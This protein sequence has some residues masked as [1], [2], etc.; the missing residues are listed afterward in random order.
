MHTN[1]FPIIQGLLENDIEVKFYTFFEGVTEDHSLL[2]PTPLK[3][4]LISKFLCFLCDRFNDPNDAETKKLKLYMPSFF[5]ILRLIKREQPDLI[6]LRDRSKASAIVALACKAL[7]FKNIVIYNQ[8]S[9]DFTYHGWKN[10][11]F[12]K[13]RYTPV[14]SVD[15][16]GNVNNEKAEHTYFIPFVYDVPDYEKNYSKETERIKILD[17]GKYRDYKNH[18]ILVEAAKILKDRQIT[19]FNITIVGQVNNSAEKEYFD[20][21]SANINSLNLKENISLC[22]SV[23]YNQIGNLYQSHD[24]LVLPS[25]KELAGMV[26]LESMAYGLC[27]ISSDNNG[28][29]FYIVESNAGCLFNHTSATDLA[30]KLESYILHPQLIAKSGKNGKEYM[31]KSCSKMCYISNLNQLCEREF[32]FSIFDR[33][34]KSNEN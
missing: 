26:I 7:G 22:K 2:Q 30:D 17:I 24:I 6:I 31:K 8:A 28:T 23:P 1:Q 32:N 11:F 34:T 16:D 3:K 25:K 19:N 9:I 10:I 14:K 5:K 13:T 4:S 21:L 15:S 18:F 27:T 12:P 33:I 29:A 20:K